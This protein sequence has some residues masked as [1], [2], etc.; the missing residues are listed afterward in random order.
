[1][2]NKIIKVNS[3]I[4]N[5]VIKKDQENFV[6]V[7]DDQKP[8]YSLSEVLD[9]VIIGDCLKVMKKLPAESFDC[10]FIDPPYFLQLSPKK[11][12]NRN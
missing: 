8:T 7:D 2:T 5:K 11:L 1:M 4:H 6:L 9:K 10:V 12:F 3:D